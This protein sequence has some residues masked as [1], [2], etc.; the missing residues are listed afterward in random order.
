MR[1]GNVEDMEKEKTEEADNLAALI[2]SDPEENMTKSEKASNWWYYYKWYVIVGIVIAAFAFHLIGTLLGFWTK[3][4]DFQIAYVGSY[5]LPEETITALEQG[6]ASIAEDFNG[7]GE[8]IVQ[9][10]QYSCIGQNA[11]SGFGYYEYENEIP[12]IGDISA[13][14]SFFFLT[15]DPDSL[16]Q[17]FQIF[18]DLDGNRPDDED[19]SAEGKVIAWVDSPILAEMELGEYIPAYGYEEQTITT[20]QELLSGLYIGRRSFYDD[21]VSDNYEK[22]CELWD[23]IR[24]SRQ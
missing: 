21:K 11:D 15:D 2:K 6:F 16:Q 7:D 17:T 19:Y 20:N 23:L 10:N 24:S 8:I 14:D 1:I 3:D 22:C 18:S 12:L 13:C 5:S 9:I 4:P